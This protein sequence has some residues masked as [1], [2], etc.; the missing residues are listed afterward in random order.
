MPKKKIMLQ[1]KIYYQH[2]LCVECAGISKIF[3]GR[4]KQMG[5][6]LNDELIVGICIW[7]LF[8]FHL[9]FIYFS[10]GI[11]HYLLNFK[12]WYSRSHD[13]SSSK[14]HAGHY[15]YQCTTTYNVA[16][17]SILRKRLGQFDS[18]DESRSCPRNTHIEE[19]N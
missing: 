6:N 16:T 9:V 5:R 2:L 12:A 8:I 15:A 3:K 18:L 19:S 10:L 1:L 14:S 11:C 13:L 17:N 4:K 7:Y